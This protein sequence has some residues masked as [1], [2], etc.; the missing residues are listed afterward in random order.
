MRGEGSFCE[1]DLDAR[2]DIA[3]AGSLPV[4]DGGVDLVS[5]ERGP[6]AMLT[7]LVKSSPGTFSSTG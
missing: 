4:P 7:V 2:Y 6:A 1:T 5:A 3:C